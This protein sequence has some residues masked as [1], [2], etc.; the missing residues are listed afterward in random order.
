MDEPSWLVLDTGSAPLQ[1]VWGDRHK[2]TAGQKG[3]R[4][5][6]CCLPFEN[7]AVSIGMD[8]WMLST[9]YGPQWTHPFWL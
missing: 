2:A 1:V 4:E 5:G 7:R 9:G 8:K 3:E 6:P